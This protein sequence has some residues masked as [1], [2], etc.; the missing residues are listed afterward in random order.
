ML[1]QMARSLRA[2]HRVDKLP[3]IHTPE[4]LSR[5]YY[6]VGTNKESVGE[7]TVAFETPV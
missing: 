3:T 2:N 7:I 5:Q 1:N 6:E 4:Q